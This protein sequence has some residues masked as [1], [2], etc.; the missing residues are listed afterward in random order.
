M[1]SGLLDVHPAWIETAG[2]PVY[3]QRSYDQILLF[4]DTMQVFFR[5]FNPFMSQLNKI[6]S[7]K[8]IT[9]L[10]TREKKKTSKVNGLRLTSVG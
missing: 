4:Y 1:S 3:D 9:D 6:V 10:Q 2:K 8:S 5:T 7:I